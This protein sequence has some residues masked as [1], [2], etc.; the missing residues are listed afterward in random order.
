VNVTRA[1]RPCSAATI[2]ER[3]LTWHDAA[4]RVSAVCSTL[5]HARIAR[6]MKSGETDPSPAG[7]ERRAVGDAPRARELENERAR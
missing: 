6:R 7:K 4:K 5:A 1:S 3:Q 2:G